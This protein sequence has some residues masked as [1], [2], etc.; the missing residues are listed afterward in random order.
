MLC[1]VPCQV[2]GVRVVD[3]CLCCSCGG[4]S[5]VRSPLVVVEG[6]AVVD[7]GVLL[8]RWGGVVEEGRPLLH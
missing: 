7:G 5:S 4:V 1:T 8:W 2:H 6:G 3:V